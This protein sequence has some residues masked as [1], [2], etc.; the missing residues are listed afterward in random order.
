MSCSQD[1][2]LL[3]S[4]V[5]TRIL[6]CSQTIGGSRQHAL[7][8]W[9]FKVLHQF[10]T[11]S[12]VLYA[13]NYFK[14]MKRSCSMYA[15]STRATKTHTIKAATR[16]PTPGTV[17][18]IFINFYHNFVFENL[19]KLKNF[20]KILFLEESFRHVSVGLE[21]AGW[22]SPVHSR[23]GDSFDACFPRF[24]VLNLSIEFWIVIC[25]DRIF[26]SVLKSS[27]WASSFFICQRNTTTAKLYSAAITQS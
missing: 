24:G 5:K 16:G 26:A 21:C 10:C 20:I 2:T 23:Q 7:V 25:R 1:F 22:P 14:E 15:H 17:V 6:A 27:E 3:W 12:G 18:G 13:Q 9:F 11:L 4:R 19:K 8:D